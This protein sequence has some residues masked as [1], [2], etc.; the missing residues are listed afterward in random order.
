MTENDVVTPVV[1][2][3]HRRL[4]DSK[5]DGLKACDETLEKRMD[6]IESGIKDV[7]AL[8]KTLLYAIIGVFGTSILI[9]IGVIAGRAIDF[10]FFFP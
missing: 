4:T 7:L 10:K 1:C 8:Q 6:G 9:L 3:L 5:I 2:E